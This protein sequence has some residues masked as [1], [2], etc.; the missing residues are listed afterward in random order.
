MWCG[1]PQP[2]ILKRMSLFENQSKSLTF[3]SKLFKDLWYKNKSNAD[4]EKSVIDL[5]IQ[6][7]NVT[8]EKAQEHL[9]TFIHSIMNKLEMTENI[10]NYIDLLTSIKDSLNNQL[11][12]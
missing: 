5:Y 6:K 4:L 2:A 11:K 9:S 7:N 3:Q 8:E 10:N 1:L 12:L